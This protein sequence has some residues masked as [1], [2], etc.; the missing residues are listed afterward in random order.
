MEQASEKITFRG[1]EAEAGSVLPCRDS[2]LLGIAAHG[3]KGRVLLG[4]A[5]RD[6]KSF[7][8][9]FQFGKPA[10][11]RRA[12]SSLGPLPLL[13]STGGVFLSVALFKAAKIPQESGREHAQILQENRGKNGRSHQESSSL[14]FP[15]IWEQVDNDLGT[16][17]DKGG[18]RLGHFVA[19]CGV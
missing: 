7:S 8:A 17:L 4:P 9:I 5:A 3:Q 12:S 18:K 14:R 13:E 2:S 16:G 6:Q 19:V 10:D 1:S 15:R 11:R